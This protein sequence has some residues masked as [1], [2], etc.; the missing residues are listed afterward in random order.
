VESEPNGNTDIA[1]AG[2]EM[3][4]LPARV[5]PAACSA[6]VTRLQRLSRQLREELR[7]PSHR[8]DLRHRHTARTSQD[9]SG[10]VKREIGYW[11]KGNCRR[12][13]VEPQNRIAAS[14]AVLI[15]SLFPFARGLSSGLSSFFISF[16][17]RQ[18]P[19]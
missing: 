13:K 19:G 17:Q 10:V 14:P 18:P 1:F 8:E 9:V 5:P 3:S 6:R 15:L 12:I 11:S 7:S 16:S 4:A 2:L